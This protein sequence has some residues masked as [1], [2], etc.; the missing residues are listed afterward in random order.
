MEFVVRLFVCMQ[1]SMHWLS[2]ETSPWKKSLT[3]PRI[4]GSTR[5]LRLATCDIV[6]HVIALKLVDLKSEIL[7]FLFGIVKVISHTMV[8]STFIRVM[9]ITINLM[10]VLVSI[11]WKNI[12][13]FQERHSMKLLRFY[14]R[15]EWKRTITNRAKT[16]EKTGRFFVV[17]KRYGKM[18]NKRF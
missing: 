6:I 1:L 11:W 12:W 4:V 5:T 17:D 3:C 7:N 2:A 15:S 18:V 14:Q 8:S 10:I 9:D 16:R 13:R